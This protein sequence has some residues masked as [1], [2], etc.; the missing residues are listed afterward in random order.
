MRCA[1]WGEFLLEDLS[2]NP[3]LWRNGV[4]SRWLGRQHQSNHVSTDFPEARGLPLGLLD[5]LEKRGRRRASSEAPTNRL[6][7]RARE[8]DNGDSHWTAGLGPL[9]FSLER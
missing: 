9:C 8:V 6:F 1:R 5:S 3:Q 7:A 4:S 2:Y